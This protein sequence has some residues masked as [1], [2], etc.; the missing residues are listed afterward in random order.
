[1]RRERARG[2]CSLRAE[3]RK[4]EEGGGGGEGEGEGRRR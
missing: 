3:G 1:M 2:G 4:D